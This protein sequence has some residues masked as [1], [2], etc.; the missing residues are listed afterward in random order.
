MIA[1]ADTFV[2][3]ASSPPSPWW[4]TSFRPFGFQHFLPAGLALVTMAVLAAVGSRHFNSANERRVRLAIAGASLAYAITVSIWYLIPPKLNLARSLPLHMCDVMVLLA[5]LA[6]ITQHRTLRSLNCFWGVALCSQAF[7]TP[8]L[9][10]GLDD[11]EYYF[12]WSSHFVIVGSSLYDYIAGRFRPTLRDFGVCVAWGIVWVVAVF[13]INL[14]IDGANY[15][16]VGQPVAGQPT[17]V[18]QLG[19]WPLRA[20]W[21][22]LIAIAGC[23]LIFL[24]SLVFQRC[25]GQAATP[26]RWPTIATQT[27]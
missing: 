5:P 8:I 16:Y 11:A 18:D 17:I 21:V 12:F 2:L 4:L 20:L 14:R 22:A 9:T 15:G 27:R 19:P 13:L 24:G 23:G 10:V 6:L 7:I 26:K 25:E 3:L 1:L